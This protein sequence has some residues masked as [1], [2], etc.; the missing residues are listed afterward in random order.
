MIGRCGKAP[1]CPICE[2]RG[3]RADHRPG[4]SS[5][6]VLVPPGVAREDGPPGGRPRSPRSVPMKG[7]DRGDQGGRGVGAAGEG[8]SIPPQAAAALPPPPDSKYVETGG[9]ET[10][11]GPQEGSPGGDDMGPP[12]GRLWGGDSSAP[13][14]DMEVEEEVIPTRKRKSREELNADLPA[15]LSPRRKKGGKGKKKK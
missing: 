13:S 14:S 6:C 5:K 12:S 9:E 4:D 3:R 7:T 8:T 1:H 11:V 2:E 15:P 10:M